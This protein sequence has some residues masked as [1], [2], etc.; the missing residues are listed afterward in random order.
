[1]SILPYLL[2][3]EYEYQIV[4]TPKIS[5]SSLVTWHPFEKLPSSMWHDAREFAKDN[6]TRSDARVFYP[7][8][9]NTPTKI[10]KQH[11]PQHLTSTKISSTRHPPNPSCPE[12]CLSCLSRPARSLE[13]R[14]H[15][16]LAG[17]LSILDM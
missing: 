4:R 10:H 16:G 7:A 8:C 13:S 3:Y 15:A 17:G 11:Q 12:N 6:L 5:S 14:Q 1:M 2:H 9:S